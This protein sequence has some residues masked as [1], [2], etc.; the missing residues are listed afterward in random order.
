MTYYVLD[1]NIIA[2]ILRSDPL[3][4]QRFQQAL[5]N[6]EDDFFACPMVY[7]EVRRGLIARDARKQFANF[8]LI[9]SDFL[10][11]DYLREDW[12]KAAELWAL[13]RQLG[14]PIADAD[15]LIVAFT[16][17]RDGVLVTNNTADFDQLGAK[18]EDWTI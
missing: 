4:M 7:F 2:K 16:I 5:A 14:R 1:S 18:L 8:E 10:W 12:Q 15:L 6:E 3:V 11:Q 13:R 17:N 9:Y